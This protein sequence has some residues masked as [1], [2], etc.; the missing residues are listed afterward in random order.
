MIE[1]GYYIG[2]GVHKEFVQMAVFEEAGENPAYGRRLNND[3]A[4]LVKEVAGFSSKGK[5]ETAYEAGSLGYVIQRAMEEAGIPCFVLP[6]NKAAKQRTE[7]IKTG[8]RERG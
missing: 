2:M 4:Q 6:A 5:A 3:T 7:R 8:K 1:K